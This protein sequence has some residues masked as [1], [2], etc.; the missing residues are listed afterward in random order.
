MTTLAAPRRLYHY[1]PLIGWM[2]RDLERDFRGHIGY[3][4]LIVLTALVLALKTWGLVAL[5]LAALAMVPV[6]FVVL[7]LLTRG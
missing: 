7:I 4:A 6:M 5:G 3:A 1:I 2:L